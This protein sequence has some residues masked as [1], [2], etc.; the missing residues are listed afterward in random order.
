MSIV[1][2]QKSICVLCGTNQSEGLEWN[3]VDYDAYKPLFKN[4][5]KLRFTTS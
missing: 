4:L 1:V 3:I 5:S 2:K